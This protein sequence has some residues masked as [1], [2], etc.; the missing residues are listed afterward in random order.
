M[1]WRDLQRQHEHNLEAMTF[2]VISSALPCL[3]GAGL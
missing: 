2:G 3:K 1:Y